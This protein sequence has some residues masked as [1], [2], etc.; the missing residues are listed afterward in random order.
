M[1][2]VAEMAIN[3][4]DDL[5]ALLF[6]HRIAVGL[7]QV[8]EPDLTVPFVGAIEHPAQEPRQGVRLLD[9]EH[10]G[11][12]NQRANDQIDEIIK[13]GSANFVAGHGGQSVDVADSQSASRSTFQHVSRGWIGERQGHGL[14]SGRR[15]I[16][17][18]DDLDRFPSFAAVDGGGCSVVDRLEE[19]DE[20]VAVADVGDAARVAGACLEARDC[21]P[22]PRRLR[23]RSGPFPGNPRA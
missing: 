1:S 4:S 21:R 3:A 18:P 7:F 9:R 13:P 11:K 22:W 17:G 8:I 15:A 16:N 19:I 23:C 6:R 2:I 14:A 12:R 5:V 10:L 20:L